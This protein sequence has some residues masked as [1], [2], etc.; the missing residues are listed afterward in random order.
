MTVESMPRSCLVPL[1]S[2]AL[3]SQSHRDL[4][5][6]RNVFSDTSW[7]AAFDFSRHHPRQPVRAVAGG[8]RIDTA[9][10]PPIRMII[11]ARFLR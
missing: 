3:S 2:S 7:L 5:H 10:V 11:R 8:F 6:S 1:R 9:Q 4:V